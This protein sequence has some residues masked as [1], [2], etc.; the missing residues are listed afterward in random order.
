MPL[1]GTCKIRVSLDAGQISSED[2]IKLIPCSG[3]IDSV[4]L[5]TGRSESADCLYRLD[6]VVYIPL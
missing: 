4:K 2:N 3:S 1:F 5:T 6:F